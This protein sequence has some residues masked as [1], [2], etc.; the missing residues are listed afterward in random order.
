MTSPQGLTRRGFVQGC[1]ALLSVVV[2]LPSCRSHRET[3]AT[4]RQLT[5]GLIDHGEWLAVG[6]AYLSS[7]P[8]TPRLEDLVTTLT[9]DLEW[10]A[11]A[12]TRGDLTSSLAHRIRDDFEAGRTTLVEGWLLA[13][14]EARMAAVVALIDG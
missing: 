13:E 6:A 3:L 12:Q 9:E 10:S 2:G 7:R 11:E 4:A 8:D 14:S 1:V 5:A